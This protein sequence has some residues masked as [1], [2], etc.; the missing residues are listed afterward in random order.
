M[1][2][3]LTMSEDTAIEGKNSLDY[4]EIEENISDFDSINEPDP[5]VIS[6]SAREN[7]SENE[8]EENDSIF[9]EELVEFNDDEDIDEEKT[10]KLETIA[11][12][13]IKAFTVKRR[14]M[15]INKD[16]EESNITYEESEVRLIWMGMALATLLALLTLIGLIWLKSLQ[17]RSGIMTTYQSVSPSLTF[18]RPYVTFMDLLGKGY[19]FTLKQNRNQTFEFDWEFKVPTTSSVPH[20][21]ISKNEY[22]QVFEKDTGYFIYQDGKNLFVISSNM[23]QKVM[24]IRSPT[25]HATLPKSQIIGQFHKSGSIIRVGNFALVSGGQ[26]TDPSNWFGF[27]EDERY[28]NG[29]PVDLVDKIIS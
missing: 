8:S 21:E 12:G 7:V 9:T 2:I 19:L 17:N 22:L 15:L 3:E 27:L 11:D 18:P 16:N 5:E 25:I 23:K 29:C 6:E 14:E 28:Y 1:T 26:F 4:Q 20:L 13:I 24:M 10:P